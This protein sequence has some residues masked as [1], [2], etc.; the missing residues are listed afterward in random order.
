VHRRIFDDDAFGVN[1]AL[2]ETAFGV[3]LVARGQHYL[4]F[5]PTDKQFAIERLLAQKKLIKPQYFFAKKKKVVSHEDLK[6]DSLLQVKR[7]KQ[8]LFSL[9]YSYQ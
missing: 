4:T 2:N 5:G 6:K 8:F 7:N 1:E 9:K 3:G